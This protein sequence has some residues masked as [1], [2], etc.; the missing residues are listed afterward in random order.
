MDGGCSI[1]ILS[2][3]F[4]ILFGHDV[5]ST[6]VGVDGHVYCNNTI[7]GK[8]IPVQ[9]VDVY[10]ME[11]DGWFMFFIILPISLLMCLYYFINFLIQLA[12]YSK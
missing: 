9:G 7:N 3:L 12:D 8:E 4:L 5:I 10:L 6:E 2:L 11:E 1:F